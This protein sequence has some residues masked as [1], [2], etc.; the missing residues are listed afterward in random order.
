MH[1]GNHRLNEIPERGFEENEMSQH[2]KASGLQGSRNSGYQTEEKYKESGKWNSTI[3]DNPI[4]EHMEQLGENHQGRFGER[5]RMYEIPETGARKNDHSSKFEA[6]DY[7][8]TGIRNDGGHGWNGGYQESTLHHQESV[9]CYPAPNAQFIERG[10]GFPPNAQYIDRGDGFPQL[11]MHLQPGSTA[12]NTQVPLN[13]QYQTVGQPECQEGKKEKKPRKVWWYTTSRV[14]SAA[15][16]ITSLVSDWLEYSDMNDAIGDVKDKVGDS[17]KQEFCSK[18][19]NEDE[20]KQFLYFTI[21]GTVLA[22]LQLANIIYQI[23][24]NHRL[25][26]D[27][28]IRDWLDERTEVFLVN[29]FVKFPQSFLIHRYESNICLKCGTEINPKKIKGLFNGI[30]SM[31][32]SIWRYLTYVKVSAGSGGSCSCSSLFEKCAARCGKCIKGCLLGCIKCLCPCCCCCIDCKTFL[33]C[34]CVYVICKNSKMST[35][36]ACKGGCK[37]CEPDSSSLLADLA[38][39]PTS[40]VA[41]LNVLR[42]IKYACTID[43]SLVSDFVYDTVLGCLWDWVFK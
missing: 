30:S 15:L 26:P 40:L 37:L 11:N 34:C 6:T 16:I 7:I 3:H 22:A 2:A 19:P 9:L 1:K 18:E 4:Q 20:T 14:F 28:D 25:P 36:S 10:Y 13:V 43:I 31:A 33:P 8:K 38:S 17:F 39:F 29:A 5:S 42:F 24:Q 35:E 27:T 23:V 12:W 32:S 21:A 41:F